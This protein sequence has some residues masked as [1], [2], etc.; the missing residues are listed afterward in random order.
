MFDILETCSADELYRNAKILANELTSEDM[1]REWI[2]AL[3]RRTSELTVEQ[4]KKLHQ[5]GRKVRKKFRMK[6]VRLESEQ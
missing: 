2:I 6:P 5:L 1:A 4:E 3:F